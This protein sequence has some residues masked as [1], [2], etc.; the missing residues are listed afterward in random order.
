MSDGKRQVVL[1]LR[2]GA[3][4]ISEISH[5]EYNKIFGIKSFWDRIRDRVR[6]RFP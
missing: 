1:E 4:T 2:V 6:G 5:K 3:T